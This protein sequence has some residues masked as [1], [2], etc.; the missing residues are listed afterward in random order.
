MALSAQTGNAQ[1]PDTA[2]GDEVFRPGD[3]VGV[4]GLPA[5]GN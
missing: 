5:S 1:A 4:E 3:I 2:P